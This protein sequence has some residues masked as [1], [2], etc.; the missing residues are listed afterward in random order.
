MSAATPDLKLDYARARAHELL[1]QFRLHDWQFSF[2]SRSATSRFGDCNHARRLIRLSP[3]LTELNIVDEIEDTIRHEIAHAR[4]NPS[5]GHNASFYAMCREVGA[6]PERCYGPSVNRPPVRSKPVSYRRRCPGCDREWHYRG[7]PSA[8]RACPRCGVGVFI[9][10]MRGDTW[11]RRSQWSAYCG[12]YA[13]RLLE[14][15]DVDIDD[16]QL[17]VVAQVSF[18]EPGLCKYCL[19]FHHDWEWVSYESEETRNANN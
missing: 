2:M 12:W 19:S 8:W 14:D 1:E 5:D 10:R 16:P 6:K 3:V 17:G 4:C 13:G 15:E 9:E 18:D 7:H 11:E